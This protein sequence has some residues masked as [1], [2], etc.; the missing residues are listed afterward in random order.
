[1]ID[2]PGAY[3]NYA[4]AVGIFIAVYILGFVLPLIF[5][6]TGSVIRLAIFSIPV[7]LAG[8][9]V[10]QRFTVGVG[11]D[12]QNN[13][14]VWPSGVARRGLIP[15][16]PSAMATVVCCISMDSE[17]CSAIELRVDR[18]CLRDD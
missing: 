11:S 17:Y 12:C 2:Q 15:G 5:G 6:G 4:I 1:M 7:L 9:R 10:A 18:P 8:P 3:M 13:H 16:F 14:K